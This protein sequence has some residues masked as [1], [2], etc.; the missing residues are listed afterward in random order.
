MITYNFYRNA[1]LS[2]IKALQ[3]VVPDGVTVVAETEEDLTTTTIGIYPGIIRYSAFELGNETDADILSWYGAI[4][5]NTAQERDYLAILVYNQLKAWVIPVLDYFSAEETLGNLYVLDNLMLEP[6][7]A[8]REV[9][10]KL[11]YFTLLSFQTTYQ[12]A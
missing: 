5:A 11:R 8:P 4:Y 1:S 7:R 6:N 3:D 2:I 9:I 12:E 10:D